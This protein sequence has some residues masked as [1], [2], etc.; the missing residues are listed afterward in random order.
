MAIVT[1]PL[2]SSEARGAVGGLVYNTYRGRS[3]VKVNTAPSTQY[4]EAQVNARAHM[5]PVI[6]EW[7]AI[8]DAQRDAWTRY[9]NDHVLSHWTGSDKRLS[10]WNWFAKINWRQQRHGRA[11][12]SDPPVDDLPLIHPDFEAYGSESFVEILWT[13]IVF[14][15]ELTWTFLFWGAGP[16]SAAC[17]PQFNQAKYQ[18]LC[19]SGDAS[20]EYAV[21]ATGWHTIF[22]QLYNKAGTVYAPLVFRAL[23]E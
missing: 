2:H 5:G 11:L 17:H 10:A 7:Q 8:T 13:P 19:Y 21:T 15:D 22:I 6:A 18:D 14:Q 9:A 4:S 16:H 23:C 3:Y 20:Y 12:F 1:G